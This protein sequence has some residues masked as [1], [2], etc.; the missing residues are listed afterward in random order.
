MFQSIQPILLAT[1]ISS[2]SF[3]AAVAQI[4]V[5]SE[6]KTQNARARVERIRHA[7][8][9]GSKLEADASDHILAL[10]AVVEGGDHQESELAIRSLAA[11][12]SKASPA[13]AAMCKK[14]SDPDHATRVAAVDALV[15]IGEDAVVRLR[16]M[17]SS[18]AART[19]AAATQALARLKRLDLDSAARLSNDSDPRVRA[20]AVDALTGL[21]I[22]SVPRLAEMLLDP[23]LA[24]AVEAAR[25][26]KS[27]RADA[28]IAIPRLTHA[29][30]CKH[31]SADAGLALSAHG[32]AAQGAVPALIKADLE[33]ALE[34]IGPPS[35]LD[36]PQV[37]DSLMDANV[38]I[39]IVTAKCLALLGPDGKQASAALEVAADKSIKEYVTRKRNGKSNSRSP[40]DNSGRLFAAGE[41]CAAAVWAVTHDMPRFLN[42]VEKL[43]IAADSPLSWFSFNRLARDFR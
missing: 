26:L 21:G 42:L 23:D 43:A 28:Q 10:I 4:P 32:I 14:L 33:Q 29:V 30:S 37:C 35:V 17:L 8:T 31:L 9:S 6:S 20:A 5:E 3:D 24:V 12:K 19:R 22:P 11:L 27:N 39:R 13:I 25:A 2:V 15:A 38:K 18:P 34:H 36:I 7:V 16:E 40:F 1:I 41:N